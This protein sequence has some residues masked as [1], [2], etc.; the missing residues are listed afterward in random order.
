MP[1]LSVTYTTTDAH[2]VQG[3]MRLGVDGGVG[4]YATHLGILRCVGF[5][6]V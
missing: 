2:W 4:G 5:V 6:G 3:S 1:P